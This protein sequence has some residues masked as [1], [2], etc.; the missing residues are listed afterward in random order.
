MM[1]SPD[2]V[3]IIFSS[4]WAIKSALTYD[5]WGGIDGWLLQIIQMKR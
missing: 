3:K 5:F 4:S 1:L 2:H